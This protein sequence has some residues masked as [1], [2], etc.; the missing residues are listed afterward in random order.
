MVNLLE[1]H[2]SKKFAICRPEKGVFKF[3]PVLRNVFFWCHGLWGH[4]SQPL[5]LPRTSH[6]LRISFQYSAGW[7]VSTTS[8]VKNVTQHQGF[9]DHELFS[10]SGIQHFQAFGC[11]LLF[12]CFSCPPPPLPC[13]TLTAT[14]VRWGHSSMTFVNGRPDHLRRDNWVTTPFQG[15]P[16]HPHI[17]QYTG[18]TMFMGPVQDL[19]CR[20]SSPLLLHPSGFGILV[21]VARGGGGEQGSRRQYWEDSKGKGLQHREFLVLDATLACV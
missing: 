3:P 6:S 11:W 16:D 10:T 15:G 14:T 5:A 4:V 20:R 17:R 9:V 7:R 8:D 12:P 18:H 19:C 1:K 13:R 21:L 2:R